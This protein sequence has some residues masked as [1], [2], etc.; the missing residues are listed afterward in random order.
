MMN[1]LANCK[2]PYQDKYPRIL[3]VCSAG[4]LRSPSIALALS[5][6]PYNCN[7]RAVGAAKEYALIPVDEVLL[8][9]ADHV[10]FANQDNKTAVKQ[11]F[12]VNKANMKTWWCLDLPDSFPYRDATLMSEIDKA[13]IKCGLAATLCPDKFKKAETT[14]SVS[15]NV[16]SKAGKTRR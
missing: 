4:L 6:A 5:I 14:A 9:W 13:V 15:A 16:K 10:V 7:T 12:K 3:C 2:N 11:D 8:A 1:R